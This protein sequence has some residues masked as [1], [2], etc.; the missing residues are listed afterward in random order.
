MAVSNICFISL[1]CPEPECWSLGRQNCV[2][3]RLQLE[4]NLTHDGDVKAI[5]GTCHHTWSLSDGMKDKLRRTLLPGR[6]ET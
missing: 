4:A 3:D 6:S 1:H 5:G 2:F